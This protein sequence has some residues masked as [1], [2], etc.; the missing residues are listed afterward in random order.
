[1][2]SKKS[3]ILLRKYVLLFIVFFYFYFFTSY[4]R[5]I[6]QL[7]LV[8]RH[9]PEHPEDDQAAAADDEEQGLRSVMQDQ[10]RQSNHLP[11]GKIYCVYDI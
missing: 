10:E 8:Q 7:F 2:C 5:S 3:F 11:Q 1:M 6:K 9:W 4:S